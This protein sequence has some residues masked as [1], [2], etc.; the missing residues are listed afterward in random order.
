MMISFGCANVR[1][2]QQSWRTINVKFVM[3]RFIHILAYSSL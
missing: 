2:I 1:G 3:V